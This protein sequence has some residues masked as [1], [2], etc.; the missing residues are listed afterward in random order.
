M[1]D[2]PAAAPD[3]TTLHPDLVSDVHFTIRSAE[4]ARMRSTV[5]LHIR[6]VMQMNGNRHWH[7]G[8]GGIDISEFIVLCPAGN[9]FHLRCDRIGPRV[10]KPAADH[11]YFASGQAEFGSSAS[12]P[13]LFISNHFKTVRHHII[14]AWTLRNLYI[15]VIFRCISAKIERDF[16]F[17]NLQRAKFFLQSIVILIRASPVYAVCVEG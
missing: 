8:H 3:K 11:P 12:L 2:D 4:Y 15:A 13:L 17:C 10:F 16:S 7:D 6:P 5:V 9:E 14:A 1:C